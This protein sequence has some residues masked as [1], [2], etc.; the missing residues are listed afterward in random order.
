MHAGKDGSLAKLPSYFRLCEQSEA[1]P[2]SVP[3]SNLLVIASLRS[4][5][6]QAIPLSI[7]FLIPVD[8]NL[9]M[10]SRYPEQRPNLQPF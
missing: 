1:I 7:Y 2:V 3:N 10:F 9:Q 8:A 6:G 5:R 4:Q